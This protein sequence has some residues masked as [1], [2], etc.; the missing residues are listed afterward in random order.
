MRIRYALS[1]IV[2]ALVIIGLMV[3]QAY[4]LSQSTIVTYNP[5]NPGQSILPTEDIGDVHE[6]FRMD[7]TALVTIPQAFTKPTIDGVLDPGEWTDA[8]TLLPV[9]VVTPGSKV[10]FKNDAC[11]LY[12]GAE[13][14]NPS[15]YTG[16]A[17]MINIWFDQN[18][19][20]QWDGLND[21]NLALPAPGYLYPPNVASIGHNSGPGNWATCSGCYLRFHYPWYSQ[22]YVQPENLVKVR[23]VQVSSNTFIVEAKIDYKNGPMKLT[24]GVSFNMR[25]QI[26][27][28]YYTGGGT[29][30]IQAQWPTRSGSYYWRSPATAQ[31]DV[32]L[33]NVIAAGNFY[34]IN[35]VSVAD[36]PTFGS[37][38]FV[39]GT[40]FD[41]EIDYTL[42]D[43]PPQSINYRARFYG[44]HPNTSLA[45]TESG[46]VV[47][48]SMA[49]T[50]TVTIPANVPIGFY[51]IEVEAD[52]PEV[53]GI[54]PVM[55]IN[56][57]LMLGPGQIP[58]SV[59]PGD[60]NLDG[61]VNFGDKKGLN[62]YVH[63]ANLNPAWLSGFYRLPPSYPKPLAEIEY[64]GQ[65]AIPWATPEGCH[66]D[67]DGN[68]TV[69]SFDNIAIKMNWFRTHSVGSSPKQDDGFNTASFDLAQN[70]PNPFNPSTKI[71]YSVPEKSSVTLSVS[72]VLG[73]TVATL[74]NGSVQA[75]VHTVNFDATE[76]ASGNY[77][78]TIQ[79]TGEESGLS[80]S[81][82]IKMT[83][84]K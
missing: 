28:G 53:C 82:V 76:F 41:M 5:A 2:A 49:G 16:N 70:Y 55:D 83:L 40:D 19:N 75:G 59:F 51:T 62:D 45:T 22:G 68:G 31:T 4:V 72:D 79:I 78:A 73:R 81:K 6:G 20:G 26:Y 30:Q 39:S 52:D 17:N 1:A 50:A 66:M 60:V 47:V 29:V 57:V 46:S 10:Y 8:V 37:K 43:P 84:D 56:N 67:S 69:N 18:R 77:I 13:L 15:F 27:S 34:D 42:N 23:R 9:T 32:Q 38:A 65:A 14:K 12:I 64:V 7:K 24:P 21:G 33:T 3:P 80:F 74:V 35:G 54:E 58:C 44:P 61:I 63:D 48:N 71:D 25:F 11:F 36:N